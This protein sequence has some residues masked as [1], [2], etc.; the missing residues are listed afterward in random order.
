MANLAWR[1]TCRQNWKQYLWALEY[2]VKAQ[3]RVL[4]EILQCMQGSA[5]LP[6]KFEDLEPRDWSAFE[7]L[8]K[9]SAEGESGLFG[10]FAIRRF[11][12]T[13]G[14][15]AGSKWIPYNALLE[16][17]FQRGIRAWVYE[18]FRRRP[19]L[20]RGPAYWSISPALPSES[21]PC[22][23]PVGFD[24]DSAYLGGLGRKIVD[25]AMAVPGSIR[26]VHVNDFQR[27]T[28]LLLLAQPDLRLISVWSPTFLISLMRY[29]RDHRAELHAELGAGTRVLNRS[30]KRRVG[31]NPWPKLGMIS[32]WTDGQ[33]SPWLEEL[34]QQFPRVPI[35]GKGLIATEAFVSLPFGKQRPL[36][37]T[38]HFLEFEFD[39]GR[40]CPVGDL[41][42]GDEA[43]VVVTTGGGLL[44]Y[45][46]G[47]RIVVTGFEGN[48]PGI[49]FLGRQGRVSDRFGEKLSEAF[50]SETLNQ[51]GLSGFSML[52]PDEMGYTL[53]T[54]SSANAEHLDQVLQ[55][56]IHYRWAVSNG[57]MR[58]ARV[59]VV[60]ADA[61]QRYLLRCEQRGQK[62][63]GIKPVALDLESGWRRWFYPDESKRS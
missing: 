44:R 36:A 22:G 23:I 5:V 30:L 11:V 10:Q 45:R 53:Y 55:Q 4:G 56:N 27:T 42:E 19:H 29:Y 6:G 13:G 46:L 43:V 16:R 47:D 9:R 59:C 62:S 33:A 1:V 51:L 40:L 12:P 60:P 7:P 52:A 28:L 48:T 38:S 41:K 39:D 15:N 49:R 3:Q 58:S 34:R 18:L 20:A 2:P 50:V 17:Q 37:V 26:S 21:T 54:E 31:G 25:R 57:Q 61:L 63:G 8:L 32:C 24:E 35:Q 14:S